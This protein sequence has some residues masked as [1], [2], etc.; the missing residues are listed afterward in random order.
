MR[1]VKIRREP[2]G[3]YVISFF[4]KEINQWDVTSYVLL[5]EEILVDWIEKAELPCYHHR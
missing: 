2:S 5:G 1:W 3:L 4:E